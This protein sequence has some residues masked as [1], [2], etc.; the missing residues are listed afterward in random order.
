MRCE[1]RKEKEETMWSVA[2][3]S[4]HKKLNEKKN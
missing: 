3:E 2:P 4:I 1:K